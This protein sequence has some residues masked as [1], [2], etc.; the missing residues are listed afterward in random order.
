[1]DED[2]RVY[3]WKNTNPVI[4]VTY[5][6]YVM[7]TNKNPGYIYITDYSSILSKLNLIDNVGQGRRKF[8]AKIKT[9]YH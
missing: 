8:F 7:K 2:V 6:E 4:N 1:M 9:T 3:T 5:L